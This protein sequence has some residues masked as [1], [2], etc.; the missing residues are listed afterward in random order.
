MFPI[1]VS[2]PTRFAPIATYGLIAANVVVFILLISLPPFAQEAVAYQYGLVPARYGDPQWALGVGLAPT[3]VLPFVTSLFLH[4]GWFHLIF[5]M[6]TLWLFGPAIEDRVGSIKYLAFYVGCGIA[7]GAAQAIVDLDSTIPLVGAS[8]AIAGVLGAYVRQ[9]PLSKVVV[10]VPIIFIPYFFDLP[11][12][13]YIALWFLA[14]VV[15]GLGSLGAMEA[16][17]IAWW[18]HIGG[19]VAGALA[20][21]F[22]CCSPRVYRRYYNDEGVFGY[23]PHGGR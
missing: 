21:P 10:L 1:S 8:G 23:R 17:G 3:N 9:F 18:A 14:Q 2:V 5:N 22:L 13:L 12:L 4:G 15:Q 6:W 11:A 19:F 16:G 20:A 7:A